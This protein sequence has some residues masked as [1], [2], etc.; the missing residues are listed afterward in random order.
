MNELS[1][2]QITIEEISTYLA[3][4]A[5]LTGDFDEDLNTI[6]T[7][8]HTALFTSMEPW[9]DYRRTGYPELIPNAGGESP[10]NPNGEIPRRLIY[11]QSERLRNTSFPQPAPNMQDRF[12]WDQ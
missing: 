11:P 12:W 3:T 6:I 9:T 2:G 1:N 8:K 7:E 4:N 5:Q 10:S